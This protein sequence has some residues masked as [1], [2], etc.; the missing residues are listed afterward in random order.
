M[1]IN[2]EQK[3]LSFDHQGGTNLLQGEPP[4]DFLC[5]VVELQ[6]HQTD[7]MAVPIDI[8]AVM[9]DFADVFAAPTSLPPRRQCDH[10]I[11]LIEGAQPIEIMPYRYSPE[12]KTEIEKQIQAMLDPGGNFFQ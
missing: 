3:W 4:A 9:H 5:T 6:L 2:W 8:Q 7:T 12:L 11:P 1:R 10:K